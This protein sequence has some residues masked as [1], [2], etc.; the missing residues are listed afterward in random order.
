MESMVSVIM[1]E[2]ADPVQNPLGPLKINIMKFDEIYEHG[3]LNFV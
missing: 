1:A 2:F 3:D